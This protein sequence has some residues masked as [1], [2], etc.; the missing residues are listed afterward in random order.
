VRRKNGGQIEDETGAGNGAPD[1]LG[2]GPESGDVDELEQVLSDLGAGQGDETVIVSKW[3]E[4]STARHGFDLCGRFQASGFD[5]FDMPRQFGPGRFKFQFARNG[6]YFRNI[7]RSFMAPIEA[8]QPERADESSAARELRE[9]RAFERQLLLAVISGRP[10]GAPAPAPAPGLSVADMLSLFKAGRE[11]ATT[12]TPLDS[13]R[14]AVN[15]GR[16]LAG[17]SSG[18]DD[19]D[20]AKPKRSSLLETLAPRAID[21]VERALIAGTRPVPAPATPPAPTS[22]APAPAPAR[23]EDPAVNLIRQFAGDILREAKAGRDPRAWG[24]F[25]GERVPDQYADDLANFAS[26]T[27]EQRQAFLAAHAPELLAYQDWVTQACAGIMDTFEEEP[28]GSE[29]AND[30]P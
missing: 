27:V 19:G 1:P 20:G 23:I 11:S 29:V 28:D 8:P 22:P 21:L 2:L 3:N 14:E 18:D 6:R 17:A 16:E 15:F 9:S 5:P 12:N 30:A 10:L 24:A 13:L 25:V 7:E 4:K 26:S